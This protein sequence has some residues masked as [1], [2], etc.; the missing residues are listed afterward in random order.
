MQSLQN[1]TATPNIPVSFPVT[2]ATPSIWQVTYSVACSQ[3]W[4]TTFSYQASLAAC[5]LSL[6]PSFLPVCRGK[7]CV[8]CYRQDV[9]SL[10]TLEPRRETHQ[11]L[12]VAPHCGHSQTALLQMEK[13]HGWCINEF[14]AGQ[15]AG[16]YFWNT[17]SR[18]L[19]TTCVII[20]WITWVPH[21]STHATK[22][23]LSSAELSSTSNDT[24]YSFIST[25]ANPNPKC[26]LSSYMSSL[27]GNCTI[28][29][30]TK[31]LH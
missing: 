8:L 15:S 31:H 17:K 2:T 25:Q 22:L 6:C 18:I 26:T 21:F 29:R 27:K 4:P 20:A 10:C 24:L 13:N 1:V 3:I 19:V 11:W 14:T 7:W 12:Q 5:C 16:I 28:Q 23:G 9:G 30:C